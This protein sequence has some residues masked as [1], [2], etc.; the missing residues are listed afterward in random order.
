MAYVWES[1]IMNPTSTP[2]YDKILLPSFGENISDLLVSLYIRTREFIRGT[3]HF[4]PR[5][6]MWW[7]ETR[8]YSAIGIID[9]YRQ[10]L[11]CAKHYELHHRTVQSQQRVRH[12]QKLAR[13][14]FPACRA[15]MEIQ[16]EQRK[17]RTD[18][19]VEKRYAEVLTITTQ[20]RSYMTER[21]GLL[22]GYCTALRGYELVC[23]NE[24]LMEDIAMVEETIHHYMK[25]EYWMDSDISFR[26]PFIDSIVSAAGNIY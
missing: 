7:Y 13:I 14:T 5:I 10:K 20:F 11:K 24:K 19:I 9:Y 6:A 23:A 17:Q 4:P 26:I 15:K 1:T 25:H 12:A 8:Q 21:T 16:L 18:A 3:Y 22:L 2:K